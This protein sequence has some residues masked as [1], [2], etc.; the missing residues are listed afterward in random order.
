MRISGPMYCWMFVE[1]WR[2]PSGHCS[3]WCCLAT[4][5]FDLSGKRTLGLLEN[6]SQTTALEHLRTE[7]C[8]WLTSVELSCCFLGLSLCFAGLCLSS[9]LLM[10]RSP[11]LSSDSVQLSWS[12]P[13][14][15]WK[16]FLELSSPSSGLSWSAQ[17]LRI[18]GVWSFPGQSLSSPGLCWR[19]FALYY[20]Y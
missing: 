17:N 11:G 9:P 12:F 5:P 20:C 4:P 2:L 3:R 10:R 16:H 7:L 14:Q 15:K 1:G 13:P 6:H 18:L 8:N 19:S